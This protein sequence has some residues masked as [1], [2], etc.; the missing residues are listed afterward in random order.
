MR[1]KV[2]NRFAPGPDYMVD[3]LKLS[4]QAP[5][6]SCESVQM[7]EAWRCSDG[8]QH[9]FCWTILTVSGQSLATNGPVVESRYLNLVFGPT[10]ETHNKLFLSSPTKY[11]VEPSWMLVRVWLPFEL[12]HRALTTIVFTQYCYVCDPIL[13]PSHHLLKKWVDFFPFGYGFADGNS[14]HHVFWC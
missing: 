7:C 4:N 3:A 6:A 5:R 11:T 12:L 9:L 13:F 2:G 14:I 10:E 1:E 8:T